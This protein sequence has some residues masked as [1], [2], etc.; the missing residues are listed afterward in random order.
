MNYRWG[1]LAASSVGCDK[2]EAQIHCLQSVSVDR[3]LKTPITSG[4]NGAQAVIDGSYTETPFLPMSPRDIMSSGKYN[5]NISLLLGYN[6][7][8]GILHTGNAYKLSLIH[9]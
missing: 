8:E 5:N 1:Q 9:I 4:P 3:L 7:D 2:G 6:K